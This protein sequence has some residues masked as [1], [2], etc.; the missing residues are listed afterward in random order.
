VIKGSFVKIKSGF[1]VGL[2]LADSSILL[3]LTA[4]PLCGEHYQ[5][6]YLVNKFP[7]LNLRLSCDHPDYS[8]RPDATIV[9]VV[10]YILR[11]AFNL[12]YQV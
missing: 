12:A 9:P 10:S 8:Q 3:F 7:V 1:I 2:G 11:V 4:S 6:Q 5:F